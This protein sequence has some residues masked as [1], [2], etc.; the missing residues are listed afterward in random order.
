MRRQGV[1]DIDSDVGAPRRAG[2]G[3]PGEAVTV[4]CVN[5]CLLLRLAP[6]AEGGEK[7]EAELSILLGE[8]TFQVVGP[9]AVAALHKR[10]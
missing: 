7:Q 9:S 5:F 10:R 6:K 8:G 2:V 3:Q 1:A 4:F